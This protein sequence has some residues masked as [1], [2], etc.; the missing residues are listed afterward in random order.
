M[1][2]AV[3]VLDTFGGYSY[4]YIGFQCYTV[5]TSVS[6]LVFACNVSVLQGCSCAIAN[7]KALPRASQGFNID[8]TNYQCTKCGEP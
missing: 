1:Y 5:Q 7:C 6:V 3:L 2:D 4:N 8:H